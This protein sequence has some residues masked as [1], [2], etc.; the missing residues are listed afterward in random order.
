MVFD[1]Q[2]SFNLDNYGAVWA[3]MVQVGILLIGLLLGNLLRNV[4]PFLKKGLIPSALLGGLIILTIDIIM[5]QCGVTWFGVTGLVDQQIMQVITYH[6]LG[7]GFVAMSLKTT[8]AKNKTAKRKIIEAGALTGGTYM[9][10]AVVGLGISIVFYLVTKGI[11]YGTGLLLPLGF[12]QGP[13]NALAWDVTFS[14]LVDEGGN[15]LFTGNGSVG[16]TIASVGFIV[17]SLVGVVYINIFRRK[18]QIVVNGH[19]PAR[20]K[21]VEMFEADNEIPDTESID[22]F[23]IQLAFVALGYAGAFGIMCIFAKISN[24]T[25]GIAWGF[26]F[27]WGVITANLIKI[28]L[29]LLKKAKV[30]KREYINN[31]QMD[32]ISGFAFDLMIVAG[33]AAI[34]IEAVKKYIWII[35]LI[36]VLG[37]VATYIYIRLITRHCYKGYEHEM[38]VTNFGALTGTASNGMILLKEIDPNFE[39]PAANLYITSQLPAIIFVAPLLLLLNFAIKDFTHVLIAFA[40]FFVLFA[41]YTT[42]MIISG[43]KKDIYIR[44]SIEETK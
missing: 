23:T 16:L 27:I 33:V 41:G 4:V 6:G 20:E 18:G 40:I 44:E 3:I 38:F 1:A 43:K 24:F 22:K 28:L 26:N 35:I 5:K 2:W 8:K 17:A 7:I 32:R 12:G 21:T 42:Y 13:G 19:K 11:F 14:S 30:V 15:A 10:Q 25:N 39:T 31:Y 29:R 9:L 37:M 36:S 34:E